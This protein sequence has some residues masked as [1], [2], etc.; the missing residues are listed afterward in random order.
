MA[1]F[2]DLPGVRVQ[3]TTHTVAR[4][5]AHLHATLKAAGIPIPTNDLWIAATALELHAP[6]ITYDAH[7][8]RIHGLKI[9]AP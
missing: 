7:F 9:E 1:A 8:G 6:L 4:R 2:L 3:E 5:Y